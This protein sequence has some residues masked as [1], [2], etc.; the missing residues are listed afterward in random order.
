VA[1][2]GCGWGVVVEDWEAGEE[3]GGGLGLVDG[4]GGE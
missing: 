4:E 2:E 1:F 3:G